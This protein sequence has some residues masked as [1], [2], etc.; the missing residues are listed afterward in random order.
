MKDSANTTGFSPHR[1][2]ALT[3]GI[4][5]VAMTLLVIELKFP[6]HAEIH[7]AEHLARA[8]VD[9]SP[10]FFSWVISFMVLAL[11]WIAHHR[12]FSHVRHV[13]G[14]LVGLNVFQLAFVSLMPFCTMLIGEYGGAL[15]SQIFY[16][17]NM[18]LLAIFS[19]LI[20]NYIHR[21][22]E[23]SSAPMSRGAYR[24]ALVRNFALIAISVVAVSVGFFTVPVIGR[25]GNAAY[26]LMFIVMPLSR[27]LEK[28]FDRAG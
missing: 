26:A 8:M 17:S 28:R 10:K 20:A 9:L 23:L 13:N 21:H 3:D 27:R 7:S 6:E 14:R 18:V 25:H 12:N 24:G 19:L 2:E 5:A 11:F 15:L 16:S 4:Y 1:I 22:S